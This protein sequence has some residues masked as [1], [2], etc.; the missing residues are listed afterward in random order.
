M[1][2]NLLFVYGE[3]RVWKDK[4]GNSYIDKIFDEV[5]WNRYYA[6]TQNIT[7][8][9]RQERPFADEKEKN[10]H[11]KV[12]FAR[13]S[14][15]S[16]PSLTDSA[17]SFL[18]LKKRNTSTKTLADV[19]LNSDAMIIRLPST[20]GSQAIGLCKRLHIPYMVELVGDPYAAL[21]H[22]SMAGKILAPYIAIKT[23]YYVEKA[24]F[25]LYV[26]REYLQRGYPTAGK[27]LSCP[28]SNIETIDEDILAKRLDR[29]QTK[30]M[31]DTMVLG[32]IGSLDVDYRG[33]KVLLRILRQLKEEGFDCCVRFLGGGN[34]ERW[35]QLAEQLGVAPQVEFCGTLPG[36]APVLRW[37]DDIDVL[38][39]PAKVESLGRA[40]IEA[41]TR[42]CPVLGTS[43]TAHRELLGSE[44]V[45]RPDDIEEFSSR[46]KKLITNKEYAKYC[47][48]EN[49]YRSH[50]YLNSMLDPDRE[51]FFIEFSKS[52][53]KEI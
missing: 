50:K 11:R 25:V 16:L 14:V 33:H 2:K 45:C 5:F 47:A 9:F 35:K 7:I 39:M 18:S 19:L 31:D 29:I 13:M 26:S 44:C 40:V 48:C 49:F 6:I 30:Q 37:I 46:I 34:K 3:A 22:H 1:L 8:C 41:M 43:T 32:L 51:A 4:E 15:C 20:V 52:T 27:A 21:H 12:D 28:D 10:D 23:K 42:G 38:V 53:K 36:G 24:P 17:S